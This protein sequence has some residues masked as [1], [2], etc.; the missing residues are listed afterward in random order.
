[1]G[2]CVYKPRNAED[3][4]QPAEAG[5]R[6]GTDSHSASQGPSHADTLTLDDWA[7]GLGDHRFLLTEPPSS[8]LT[9][10]LETNT[11]L[12]LHPF[13]DVVTCLRLISSEIVS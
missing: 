2:R 5:E 6:P 1:M 11:I 8:W 9:A 12:V 7:P 3:G 10:A 13:S 4:R